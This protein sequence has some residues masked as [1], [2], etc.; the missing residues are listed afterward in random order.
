MSFDVLQVICRGQLPCK[1]SDDT[2]TYSHTTHTHKLTPPH[3]LTHTNSHIHTPLTHTNPYTLTHIYTHTHSHAHTFTP[4]HTLTHIH[5]LSHKLTH[6]HTQTIYTHKLTHTLTQSLTPATNYYK[7]WYVELWAEGLPLNCP[8]V[9]EHQV[10][11]TR[12]TLSDEKVEMLCRERQA[13]GR[14]IR[15]FSEGPPSSQWGWESATGS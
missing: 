9:R 10:G 8:R 6:S 1:I 11:S 4:T 3:T 5:T 2:H 12:R 13:E 15:K 7:V 14:R